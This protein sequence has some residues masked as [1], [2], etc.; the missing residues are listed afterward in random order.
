MIWGG[1]KRKK[2]SCTVNEKR[3][4]IKVV[5]IKYRFWGVQNGLRKDS[6]QVYHIEYCAV[7]G[8]GG[9]GGGGGEETEGRAEYTTN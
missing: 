8:W 7:E 1:E 3:W 2:K 4:Y 9:G 5:V 6:V